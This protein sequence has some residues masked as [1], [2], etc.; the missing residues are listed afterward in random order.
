LD[1]LEQP[2]SEIAPYQPK[3]AD[4]IRPLALIFFVL[5]ADQILKVWVKTHM[6]LSGP[7]IHLLGHWFQLQF[8][9][10]NGIA[11][12]WE[13]EGHWGKLFLT[14]FRIVASF[15]IF[16]Y[17]LKL[18]KLNSTKGI[19]NSW[20]LIFAGATGNIIDSIFYGVFFKNLNVY[21]GSIFHGRVVDMLYMPLIEGH[22]PQWFPLWKGEEFVF[23]RPIFNLAD[24]SISVGVFLILL[25]Y[26]QD[27]KNV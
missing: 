27:L 14:L 20:A 4:Y 16:W 7:P 15:F 25:L 8:V 10:N 13:F 19:I 26:R 11:F 1:T 24:A 9:E 3:T 5:L 21:P 17:L 23:F 2:I 22:F 18:V 12:G 6:I